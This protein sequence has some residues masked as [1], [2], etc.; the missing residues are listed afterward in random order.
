M[1]NTK[2]LVSCSLACFSKEMLLD[3][4]L[5]CPTC[6]RDGSVHA[7]GLAHGVW[8]LLC[9]WPTFSPSV[10]LLTGTCLWPARIHSVMGSSSPLPNAPA[11]CSSVPLLLFLCMELI[12]AL[13]QSLAEVWACHLPLFTSCESGDS[14]PAS[15]PP[16]LTRGK[17]LKRIS[18]VFLPSGHLQGG[19]VLEPGCAPHRHCLRAS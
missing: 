17:G 8:P 2:S 11:L 4:T 18:C 7:W 16:S 12:S 10:A 6:Q 5:I 19:W 15:P 13:P 3:P 1:N 9:P 14:F